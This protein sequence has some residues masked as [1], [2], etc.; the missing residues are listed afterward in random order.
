MYYH[1]ESLL[2]YEA[3]QRYE[4]RC[5]AKYEASRR[6]SYRVT[7]PDWYQDADNDEE[8]KQLLDDA[9]LCGFDNSQILVE[10]M[11]F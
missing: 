1:H 4:Q 10:T 7:T 9:V 8:L 11:P 3:R 6:P 2:Q 5:D